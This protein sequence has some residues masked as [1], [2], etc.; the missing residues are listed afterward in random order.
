MGVEIAIDPLLL[1][2]VGAAIERR[3]VRDSEAAQL[4]LRCDPT[5]LSRQHGCG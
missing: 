5:P 4:A 1:C 3:V 2:T